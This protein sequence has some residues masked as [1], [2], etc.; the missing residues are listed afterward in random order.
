M[1]ALVENNEFVKILNDRKGFIGTADNIEIVWEER[2]RTVEVTDEEGNAVLDENGDVQTR[3]ETYKESTEVTTQQEVKYSKDVFTKWSNA[4]REAI[5]IYEVSVDNTNKKDEAY[6]INTDISYSFDGSSVIGSYGTATPKPLDDVLFTQSEIDT[7]EDLEGV[8]AGDVKQYGLKGLEIKKIKAQAGGLLAPTDWHVVKA[9]EVA[10]YSVPTDIAT[11][12]TNVRAKSNEMETQ[13][14]ACTT[15]DEL[16]AL[17][18]YTED[19]EGNITRP[20][21]KF[22]EEL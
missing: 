9:T 8:E 3:E 4:E 21:A 12:R 16:K 7:D 18:E 22:P 1:F 6:Y 15:V 2:T 17:Y 10:D 14:N 20:L 13:I 19:A 11:Y 5:G